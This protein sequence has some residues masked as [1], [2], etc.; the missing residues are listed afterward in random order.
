MGPFLAFSD[1]PLYELDEDAFCTSDVPTVGRPLS[2]REVGAFAMA[3]T[4]MPAFPAEFESATATED[5]LTVCRL[6]LTQEFDALAKTDRFPSSFP[7]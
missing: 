3:D 2:T 1:A 7:A 6:F 4:T 5:V